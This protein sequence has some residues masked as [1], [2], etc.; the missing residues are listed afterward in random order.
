MTSSGPP[1]PPPEDNNLSFDQGQARAQREFARLVAEHEIVWEMDIFTGNVRFIC[2]CD[3]RARTH[4]E[5][6]RHISYM[7]WKA[8]GPVR[9]P[10]RP[11]MK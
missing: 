10:G 9:G 8:R 4:L 6:D 11:K 3:R 2:E 7:V 1:A 5:L